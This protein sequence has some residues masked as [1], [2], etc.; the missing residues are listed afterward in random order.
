MNSGVSLGV[1]VTGGMSLYTNTLIFFFSSSSMGQVDLL[2][3]SL[4]ASRRHGEESSC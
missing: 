1:T 2:L 3:H 4:L